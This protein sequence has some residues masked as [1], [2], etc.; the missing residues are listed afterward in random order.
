MTP[1]F[2]ILLV[3]KDKWQQVDVCVKHLLLFWLKIMNSPNDLIYPKSYSLKSEAGLPR[4][5]HLS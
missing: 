5:E 1:T 3:Q 2:F 4:A